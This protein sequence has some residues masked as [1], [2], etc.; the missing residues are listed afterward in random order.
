MNI[1]IELVF[2][3]GLCTFLVFKRN[4][5]TQMN[6]VLAVISFLYVDEVMLLALVKGFGGQHEV[7][8]YLGIVTI[9]IFVVFVSLFERIHWKFSSV[10]V[11]VVLALNVLRLGS[12]L[13]LW[14]L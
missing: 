13:A 9:P 11:I 4:K 6:L 5:L 2:V 7:G 12:N 8:R 14:G 10:V 1:W 3:V